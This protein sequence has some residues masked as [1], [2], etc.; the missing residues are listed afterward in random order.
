MTDVQTH[1]KNGKRLT[2]EARREQL[3]AVA[4]ALLAR[5]GAQEM[6]LASV[7]ARAGVSKPIAYDHFGS[8]SGL[9]V[10]L[11]AETSRYYETDA[12]AK[13]AAAPASLPAIAKIVATAYVKCAVEA[14]P[15]V[16]VLAAAA[17][18][19]ANA[20]AAGRAMQQTHANSFQRAFSAVLDANAA[21]LPLLFRGLV[22]AA[23]AI[24][25]DRTQEK[26]TTQAAI[27]A[28]NHLLVTSLTP[29]AQPQTE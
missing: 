12:E 13:I 28:L 15:A 26:I 10:A 23:N 24:C 1:T 9:L 29:F 14:G 27:E 16:T 5:D 17:E 3:L 7:A 25:D 8:R 20:R 22:A 18:A 19:D 21:A 6:T 2:K 11:L 4:K